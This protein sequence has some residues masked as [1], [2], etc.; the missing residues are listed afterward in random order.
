MNIIYAS[1]NI[2]ASK[3]CCAYSSILF[4][5]FYLFLPCNCF[6]KPSHLESLDLLILIKWNLLYSNKWKLCCPNPLIG[7]NLFF[8]R[9][10]C[11]DA[12]EQLEREMRQYNDN[13][14]H[15]I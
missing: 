6:P 13:K 8:A 9:T 10:V 12:V 5:L 14:G 1:E 4:H 15:M 7:C 2:L 11:Q 3:K